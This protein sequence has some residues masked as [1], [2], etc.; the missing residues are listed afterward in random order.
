M[1]G[2]AGI[3]LN[4]R[5]LFALTGALLALF[6]LGY[7]AIPEKPGLPPRD[8]FVKALDVTMKASSYRYKIEIKT[9]GDGK[10]EV[11]SSVKGEKAAADRIHIWGEMLQSP[12]DFYQIKNTSYKKDE[13][14]G[15]WI[16]FEDNEVKMADLFLMELNPF[17]NLSYKELEAVEFNGSA[18]VEGE[19]HWQ[20]TARP[21]IENPSREALWRDFTYKIWVDRGSYRIRK[22]VVEA[23]SKNNA[24]YRLLLTMEFK[25]YEK[26]IVIEPPVK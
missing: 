8:A 22:A 9:I 4:R 21:V 23:T 14:S 25:D 2:F 26:N 3:T 6:F 10:S 15:E 17:Y 12:I 5:A 19:E 20:Y 1:P 16:K 24:G 7:Q 18:E 11:F 13:T